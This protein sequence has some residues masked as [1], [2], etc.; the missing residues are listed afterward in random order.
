MQL[1][2]MYLPTQFQ[3]TC[4]RNA[5]ASPM[6]ANAPMQLQFLPSIA[7]YQMMAI[8][9]LPNAIPMYVPANAV[10]KQFQCTQGRTLK[11]HWNCIGRYVEIELQ[12]WHIGEL[13]WNCVGRYIGITLTCTLEHWHIGVA[14][15]CVGIALVDT[16]ELH[17]SQFHCNS[18]VVANVTPMYV[19]ATAIPDATP[20]YLPMQFRYLPMQCQC[21]SNV[22]AHAMPTQFQ[23]AKLLSCSASDTQTQTA[24]AA[25]CYSNSTSLLK[26]TLNLTTQT[27]TQPHYSNSNS[28]IKLPLILKLNLTTQTQTHTATDTQTASAAH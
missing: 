17:W 1:Q 28:T 7:R 18:N 3:C 8:P 19:P 27:Q 5:Y 11:L 13:R 6:H 2:F 25:I 15:Q 14:F 12:W 21:N 16:L 10:P 23:C 20:M 9:L 22:H 26:L 24:S 4:Q